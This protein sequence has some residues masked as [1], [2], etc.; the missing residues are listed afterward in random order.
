MGKTPVILVW[1]SWFGNLILHPSPCPGC[2]VTY[3]R[4]AIEE[5]AAVV[6]HCVET[7]DDPNYLPHENR[8]KFQR[9]NVI[10]CNQ[11]VSKTILTR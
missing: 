5:A 10:T 2:L 6:F 1:T 11:H 9:Y 3:D 4:N 8:L 7:R